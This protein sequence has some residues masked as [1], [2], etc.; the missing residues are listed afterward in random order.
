MKISDFKKLA[1]SELKLKFSSNEI[2]QLLAILIEERLSLSR[3]DLIKMGDITID[4]D[5]ELRLK[6]DLSL[7]A[8]NK[9]LQYIIGKVNFFGLKLLVD[10]NVLIP[11]DE[12]EELMALIADDY[13]LQDDKPA[14]IIDF[15]TGSGCMALS[16]AKIFPEA[17]VEAWDISEGALDLAQKNAKLNH[18]EVY[19]Q[20]KSI[21]DDQLKENQQYDLI[22]SNP[23]YIPPSQ[24]MEMEE[25]VLQH[26][27]DLALF[28][29]EE[30]P[31]IFYSAVVKMAQANL[32]IGGSLYFE[33]NQYLANQTLALVAEG[34]KG[35]LLKDLNGNYRFIR[36]IKA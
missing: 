19:F 34:F 31:L 18:L 15:G 12:T 1:N 4:P 36:A 17:R 16:M 13:H 28:V 35:E 25:R 29:E 22:I 7:L 23:P 26:E 30:N 24:K 11:R 6:T 32:K 14:R 20:Q 10:E 27:P 8:Q 33:I 9:P 5:G 21:L 2:N 3:L